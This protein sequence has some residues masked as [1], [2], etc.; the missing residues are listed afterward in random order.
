MISFCSFSR[1]FFVIVSAT[2]GSDRTE[3][4]LEDFS[5]NLLLLM[6]C[7]VALLTHTPL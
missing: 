3:I 2:P 6:F 7:F 4:F 1:L 5:K